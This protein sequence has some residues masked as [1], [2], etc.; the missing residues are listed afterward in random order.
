MLNKQPIFEDFERSIQKIQE[1]LK[2]EKT[3]IIRDSA[4]KR[5]EICFDLA[6][7]SIK[8]HAKTKGIEC[9]SPRDCFKTAFQLKL[10][11]HNEKWLDMIKD[12]NLTAHLYEEQ[13]ADQVYSRLSD[14][15]G[16][17]QELFSQLDNLTHLKP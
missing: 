6:W 14:Y 5:F 1:V 15:L 11:D 17:F 4:I 7:K 8:L 3:D 13:Y 16:L 12:R 2:L 9:Y 10:I